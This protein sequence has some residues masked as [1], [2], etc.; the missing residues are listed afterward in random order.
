MFG[1]GGIAQM[2]EKRGDELGFRLHAHM[3]RH[4]VAH[5]WIA[6]GGAEG[7]LMR[8][9]GWRQRAMLD[10]YGRAV[11]DDRAREAHRRLGLGDQL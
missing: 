5:R 4:T 1:H 2:L 3:F 9:A 10:R 6:A 7:D 8:L 11:A